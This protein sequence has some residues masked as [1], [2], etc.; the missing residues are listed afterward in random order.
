MDVW[1]L[2]HVM[3]RRWWVV[4]PCLLATAVTALVVVRSLPTEYVV[5][6][7]VVLTAPP[8]PV[9]LGIRDGTDSQITPAGVIA[10]LLQ[11]PAVREAVAGAGATSPYTA[12]AVGHIVRVT[13]TS[14]DAGQVGPT[15]EAV[16]DAI[17]DAVVEREDALGVSDAARTTVEIIR[18]PAGPEPAAAPAV[19]FQAVGAALL[20]PAI[21]ADNPVTPSEFNALLLAEGVQGGPTRR[22]I[23]E[24]GLLDSYEVTVDPDGPLLRLTATGAREQTVLDTVAAV[25]SAMADELAERQEAS[26]VPGGQRITVQPVVVPDEAQQ[27]TGSPVGSLVAIVGL[28]LVTSAALAVLVDRVARRRAPAPQREADHLALDVDLDPTATSPARHP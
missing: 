26:E 15:A 21:V 16:L 5:T 13:A 18:R 25:I 6:A 20:R 9:D 24:Q 7:S 17:P 14:N 1:D 12:E 11:G 8:R 28:G 19:G 22:R 23:A 10:E 27:R 4:A 2:T 3:A